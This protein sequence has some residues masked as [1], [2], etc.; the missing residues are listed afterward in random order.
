MNKKCMRS[1]QKLTL[2]EAAQKL[3]ISPRVLGQAIKNG[4]IPWGYAVVHKSRCSFILN[5]S[6]FEEVEGI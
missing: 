2:Q 4:V 1:S 6:K 3:G 5:R